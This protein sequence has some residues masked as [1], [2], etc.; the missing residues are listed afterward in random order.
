[1]IDVLSFDSLTA[2]T[3]TMPDYERDI[4]P[5]KSI[6]SSDCTGLVK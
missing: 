5:I 1:M 3:E 4:R 6:S 2:A